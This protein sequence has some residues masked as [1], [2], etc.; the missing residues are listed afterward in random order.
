[1]GRMKKLGNLKFVFLVL[2]AITM[3]AG[4]GDAKTPPASGN[5]QAS[6]PQSSSTS[7]NGDAEPKLLQV[8][9][10]SM[11]KYPPNKIPNTYVEE[12][13]NR[14]HMKWDL[15]SI[16]LSAGI[17][18]YSVM[19]ASGDYPDFIPNM[20][21]P[22]SVAKWATA[23]Y[24]LP[25]GD[26]IDRLP[27]YRSLFSDEDWQLLLD[28]GGT[29]D[30]LYML[31]STASSDPMTWIYRKDAF[32]KAGIKEFPTTMEGL[33]ETLKTL[34]A[35]YPGTVGIGVRGGN[36]NNGVK[37]LMNGFRQ[38]FR[39][40][41][42]T[43]TKGF[44]NDPDQGGQV[45][46]N[47]A[48]P[49]HR[50]MLTFIA[51]LYKEGLI[52]KEFATLTQDQWKT[53][54]LNG[55]VLLD[56]QYAS[57]TVDPGFE[58]T[59]IPGG[60][61]EYARVLPSATSEPALEFK[62]VNFS[63]FGPIFSKKLANDPEKLDRLLEYIEWGATEEGALFHQAGIEGLT[64][65]AVDGTLKYKDDYNRQSVAEQH[66]FDWWLTQSN[67][68]MKSDPVYLKKIEAMEN[69]AAVFNVLPK[70][71][72]LTDEELESINTKVSALEDVA[73][74]FATKAIMGI[75][76]IHDDKVW[77]NYLSDLNKVGLAEA[78]AVYEKY[79]Q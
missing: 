53:K 9:V 72:A 36:D 55:Q 48:S 30:K 10:A 64:Y 41:N 74:Q 20:N 1:M 29:N 28:F 37:N 12:V 26:Y 75:V 39:N 57:H 35:A 5:D 68:F 79:L 22:S 54:R 14:F 62:P 33:Y 58:L 32:D 2:L 60:E 25:I 18:K 17:E 43:Y 63:L 65:E 38:G 71:A 34:K 73:L 70:S 24:L 21:S 52:E 40:P 3:L 47:L 42:N 44:W 77:D 67:E 27:T 6:A 16:P 45:V 76:D 69:N 7:N 66:G 51:K 4:C 50:D 49:K 19:F 11:P 59:D 15:E 61:W 78:L 13:Q 31:P 23:G 56:F 8:T 46:W